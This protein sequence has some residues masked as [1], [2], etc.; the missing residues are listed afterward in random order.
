LLFGSVLWPALGLPL[1]FTVL[2]VLVVAAVAFMMVGAPE[3]RGRELD[4]IV[5]TSGP[6]TETPPATRSAL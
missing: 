6:V 4:R 2:G 3:T 5:E 1:T